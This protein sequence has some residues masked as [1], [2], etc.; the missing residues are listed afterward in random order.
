MDRCLYDL[1]IGN[2]VY[3]HGAV[4]Y[5]VEQAKV[6]D[7]DMV[8]DMI[9]ENSKFDQNNARLEEARNLNSKHKCRRSVKHKEVPSETEAGVKPSTGVDQSTTTQSSV[10]EGIIKQSDVM[11]EN[12]VCVAAVQTRAQKQNDAK[13]AQN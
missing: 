13:A 5:D 12:D 8:I 3:K 2:D 4:K 9:F 10:E 7:G 6:K 1:I 11:K